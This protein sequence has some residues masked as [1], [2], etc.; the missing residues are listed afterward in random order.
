[1]CYY[2][3][4]SPDCKAA[5]F[6]VFFLFHPASFTELIRKSATLGAKVTD[7]QEKTCRWWTIQVNF[8]PTYRSGGFRIQCYLSPSFILLFDTGNPVRLY[9]L[10]PVFHPGFSSLSLRLKQH[11]PPYFCFFCHSD[12]FGRVPLR[13]LFHP[14]IPGSRKERSGVPLPQCSLLR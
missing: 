1:M 2:N 6:P 12:V 5:F 8:T 9:S 3:L 4:S 10:T 11:V 14:A 13:G 7:I